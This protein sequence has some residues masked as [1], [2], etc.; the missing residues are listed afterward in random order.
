MK[1]LPTTPRSRIRSALRQVWLRS[2][3]RLAALKN[4][5][6]CC[7]RCGVKASVAKGREVKVQV[8]HTGHVTN[9]DRIIDMVFEELLCDPKFLEVLCVECHKK[10]HPEEAQ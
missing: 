3:E 1:K 8:H 9:W 5:K 7:Q 2:R 10:E 6:N 4:A